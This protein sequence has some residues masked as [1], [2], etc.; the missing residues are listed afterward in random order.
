MRHTR[1]HASGDQ[2][3]LAGVALLAAGIGIL[4]GGVNLPDRVLSTGIAWAGSVL[5]FAVAHH[6]R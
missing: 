3:A 2:I 1:H 6:H 5:F 4:A